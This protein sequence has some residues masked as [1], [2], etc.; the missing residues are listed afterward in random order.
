[1]LDSALSFGLAC[2]FA[3]T[4][5]VSG[6]AK[7]EQRE[8]FAAILRW[9]RLL[10]AWSVGGVSRLFPWMEIGIAGALITGGFPVITTAVLFGLYLCFLIV[11]V[12]LLMSR[13]TVECGCHGYAD[14][15]VVDGV[16]TI[17]TLITTAF[18]GLRFWLVLG[19][20]PVLWPWHLA[21]S[22]LLGGGVL[23][24]GWRTWQ[25]TQ[26]CRQCRVE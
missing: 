12:L 6:L 3:V 9:H 5:S 26:M 23:W 22:I 18:A 14:E 24:L 8:Y 11:H 20:P 1:M 13:R 2:Y 4:L 10:P 7:I 25:R 21:A 15:Q 17:T 16:S 19:T